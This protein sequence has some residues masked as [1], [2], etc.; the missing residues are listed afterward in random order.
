[1]NS[2]ILCHRKDLEQTLA[3]LQEAGRT[4]QECLVLWLGQR[5]A[6]GIEVK[7]VLRPQQMAGRDFFRIPPQSMRSIMR[8]LKVERL[9]IAAQIHTHPFEAFHSEADDRWAIV[10]HVGA[11]SLVVPFFATTTTPDNF[12]DQSALFSL[13][14][15]NRWVQTPNY[16][17]SQICRIHQ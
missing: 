7:R 16:L 10:R 17:A 5:H 9:M 12:L 3:I 8:Q 4:R 11:V 15:N 13:D 14:A 1:M 2:P 6:D